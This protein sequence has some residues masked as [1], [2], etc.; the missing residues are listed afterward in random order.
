MA[1]PQSAACARCDKEDCS[2]V[3]ILP[4]LN[5]SLKRVEHV[6]RCFELVCPACHRLFSVPFRKVEYRDVTDEQLSQGFM[7]GGFMNSRPLQ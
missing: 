5:A 1:N 3:V 4:A 7:G 6:K 2:V